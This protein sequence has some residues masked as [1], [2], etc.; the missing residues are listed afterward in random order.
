MVYAVGLA[1][2]VSAMPEVV[3]AGQERLGDMRSNTPW[4]QHHPVRLRQEQEAMQSR[5]N[6]FQLKRGGD[7]GRGWVGV[8]T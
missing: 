1:R 6:V 5:F 8:N 3:N 7:G 4:F 2:F